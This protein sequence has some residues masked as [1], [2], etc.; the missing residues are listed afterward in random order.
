MMNEQFLGKIDGPFY[1]SD[2]SHIVPFTAML[3]DW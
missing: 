3:A 2:C 1:L